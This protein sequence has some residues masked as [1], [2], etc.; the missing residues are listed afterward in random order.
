MKSFECVLVGY[1]SEGYRLWDPKSRKIVTSRNVQFDE[2]CTKPDIVNS[3]DQSYQEPLI[4][5]QDSPVLEVNTED[6]NNEVLQVPATSNF[7]NIALDEVSDQKSQFEQTLPPASNESVDGEG[8]CNSL[9]S[10]FSFC[11]SLFGQRRTKD[12]Q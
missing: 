11:C 5:I 2:L 3:G 8:E 9:F 7:Q 12:L 6:E 4:V 1:T 10:L